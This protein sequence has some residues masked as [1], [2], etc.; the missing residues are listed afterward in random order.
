LVL[1]ASHSSRIQNKTNQP[2]MNTDEHR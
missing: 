2:R 1:H